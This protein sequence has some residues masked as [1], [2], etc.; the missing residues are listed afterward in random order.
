MDTT[1]FQTKVIASS[2]VRMKWAVEMPSTDHSLESPGSL[3]NTKKQIICGR[4]LKRL[5]KHF[6]KFP[7]KVDVVCGNH[8]QMNLTT[9]G[10]ICVIT[11][12]PVS[13]NGV[14]QFQ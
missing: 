14:L 12:G 13:M 10:C 4:N 8:E 3:K 6:F 2:A 11:S 5:K 1:S 7:L 9:T